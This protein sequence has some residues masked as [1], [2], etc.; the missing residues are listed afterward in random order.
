MALAH[1]RVILFDLD[2]TLTDPFVGITR[3]IGFALEKLGRAAPPP[4]DLA[5][6]IGPPLHDTFPV[7][8]GTDDSRAVDQA[9]AFY[10][11]RYA[12]VGK[13]ENEL[14]TGIPEA[15]DALVE[16]GCT[17]FVATSKLASYAGEI[18]EHFDLMRRFRAIYGSGA[19]GTHSAKP[20]LL[21]HLIEAEGLDPSAAIMIGD[22]RHD[23]EGAR[24]NGVRSI[25]VLWGFGDRTELSE[26]G[27]D[28]IAERP[29][30]IA[31]I[32]AAAFDGAR[33]G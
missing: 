21:R 19:D 15:L 24:A 7:M 4:E 31:G 1:E 33:A 30:D 18:V 10:R 29:G 22:R 6:C 13:F 12:D 9:V 32:A 8:L 3:S 26:A 20:E 11:E 5:W 27:A 14:I 25:G 17:L 2:G 16:Q 23:I 28:W